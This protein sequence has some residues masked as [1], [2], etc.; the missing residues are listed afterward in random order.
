MLFGV[1]ASNEAES[2]FFAVSAPSEPLAVSYV[3]ETMGSAYR[4]DIDS[5]ADLIQGQ[6][7]GLAELGTTR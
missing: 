3:Q 5:L 6:Y 7:S 2:R 4:V 1:V